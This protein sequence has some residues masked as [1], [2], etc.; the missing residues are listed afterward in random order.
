M[1]FDSH[2]HYDSH[3]FDEDRN[4]VLKELPAKGIVGVINCGSDLASSKVSLDLAV[5]MPQNVPS[6]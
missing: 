6:F 5:L 4:E 1:I 2:A 3:H